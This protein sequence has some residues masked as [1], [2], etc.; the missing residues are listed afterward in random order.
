[1]NEQQIKRIMTDLAEEAVPA[2]VDLW[3]AIR[4]R[5]ETSKT[6]STTGESSMD[7]S[8]AQGRRLRLAAAIVV[9]AFVLAALFLA[10]PTGQALAKNLLRFFSRAESNTQW[11]P[12][13]A[14]ASLVEASPASVATDW[15]TATPNPAD[16]QPFHGTCGSM[17]YPHCTVNQ[18]QALVKFP[19][20]GLATLPPGMQ[21]AGATGGPDAITLMYQ[22][23]KGTLFLAQSPTSQDDLQQWEIAA[24]ALVEAVSIGNLP[25]EYVQ[26][27]WTGLG[28]TSNAALGWEANPARQTLRW[29]QDGIRYTLWFYASKTPGGIALDQSKM[30]EL[31]T[32]LTLKPE[33]ARDVTSPGF[34]T[35]EQ[36]EVRAGF[37]PLE[38][39]WLPAGYMLAGA[40][41]APERN[42]ICLH[43]RYRL[44]ATAP[45]L[46]IFESY[47]WLPGVDEIKIKQTYNG[48]AIDIPTAIAALPVGG[49]EN[50][51]GTLASNGVNLGTVCGGLQMTTNK[52][53]LWR[54][55]RMS[56]IIGAVVD[57]FQGRG[58]LTNLE[59]QRVAEGLTGV[60]NSDEN[61]LDPERL[62]SIAG[63]KSLAG[64]QVKAPRR[65]LA[66][67]HFDHA[68]YQAKDSQANPFW[69]N[70]G[71]ENALLIY[72][73][74]PI[75]DGSDGRTYSLFIS[76]TYGSG[77]QTLEEL[78]LGGG[79]EPVTVNGRPGLHQQG[80]WTAD[81]AAGIYAGCMQILAW[82]E[83]DL[84]IEID[85]YLPQALPK[86]LLI[87]IAESMR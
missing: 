15:P 13:L 68:V 19:V 57:Q 1:M 25:G 83:G 74:S 79:F 6:F 46:T 23:E 20:K 14:S 29:E 10:T 69:G 42:A 63:L 12:T 65:M 82:F 2:T 62:T 39:A 58:F 22:G 66:D 80:C 24:D 34:L 4:S 44:E 54:A 70:E 11:M 3:P 60:S 61:G 36:A 16:L 72:L 18:I 31:A 38:P 52:A 28:L 7:T 17:P 53:L 56:F 87:A 71:W 45:T 27:G 64:F 76:Q 85:T 8:F 81:P 73:G 32:Q 48:Q 30:V 59:M 51:Y 78:A 37:K 41:Y 67:L 35:L 5:L 50:G 47:G 43:Y 86:E 26:G 49:S 21:F 75:G 33:I 9:A 84:R 77:Q 40:T 55:K